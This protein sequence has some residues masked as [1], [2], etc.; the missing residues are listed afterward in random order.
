MTLSFYKLMHFFTLKRHRGREEVQKPWVELPWIL[1]Y[2]Y[3]HD[4]WNDFWFLDL[5]ENSTQWKYGH[6]RS[7]LQSVAIQSVHWHKRKSKSYRLSKRERGS[8]V[9]PNL[10]SKCSMDMHLGGMGQV[11]KV[12]FQ[13]FFVWGPRP[14]FRIIYMFQNI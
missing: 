13:F 11:R 12:L 2:F 8:L 14:V 1:S 3:K 6:R 7:A 4:G 5:N 10:L 9:D